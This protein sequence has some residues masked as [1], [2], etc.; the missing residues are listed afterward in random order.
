MSSKNPT[1]RLPCPPTPCKMT[2]YDNWEA[3]YRRVIRDFFCGNADCRWENEFY[4]I[5][6]TLSIAPDLF[7]ELFRVTQEITNLKKRSN[8]LEIGTRWLSCG[9]FTVSDLRRYEDGRM[10]A[11]GIITLLQDQ[12][13][14]VFSTFSRDEYIAVTI[15]SYFRYEL[16]HVQFAIECC[17][18]DKNMTIDAVFNRLEGWYLQDLDD[19]EKIIDYESRSA[20]PAAK[21]TGNGKIVVIPRVWNEST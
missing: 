6:N 19:I 11:R 18:A 16:R 2:V 12:F 14:R 8:P 7:Y 13:S 9:I 5:R 21:R 4:L 3:T 15:V 1:N 20:M 10:A 17:K